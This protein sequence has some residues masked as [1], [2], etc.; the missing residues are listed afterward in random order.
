MFR[1][2]LFA[3]ALAFPVPA[4]APLPALDAPWSLQHRTDVQEVWDETMPPG[5][6][7]A[8]ERFLPDPAAGWTRRVDPGFTE[9][10]EQMDVP[11]YATGVAAVYRGPGGEHMIVRISRN[12]VQYYEYVWFWSIPGA[13][14]T[15]GIVHALNG[16][17]AVVLGRDY[18]GGTSAV[19]LFD[20]RIVVEVDGGTVQ[21]RLELMGRIDLDALEALRL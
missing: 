13:R 19:L 18:H 20:N 21:E 3:I 16:H 15:F 5:L 9:A 17:E 2:A 6:V 8:L 12:A 4:A 14:E 1:P 11:G 10:M 7:E